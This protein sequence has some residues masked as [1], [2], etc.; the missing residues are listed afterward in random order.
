MLK[1][2]WNSRSGLQGSQNKIDIVS[3]NI[4]NVETTGYKKLDVTFQNA[5]YESMNGKGTPIT[6]EEPQRLQQGSGSIAESIVRNYKE[7]AIIATSSLSDMAIN[8]DGF[9]ELEDNEGSSFYTRDGAF[10]IDSQGNFVHST[11]LL[12][13]ID[14]YEKDKLKS[15]FSISPIGEIISN[16]EIIGK[17]RTCNFINKDGMIATGNGALKSIEEPKEFYGT[18]IQSHLEKSN[19]DIVKELTDMIIA[20]RSF[21]MG[22]RAT[23]TSDELWQLTNN[24]RNK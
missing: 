19:V 14:G 10:K 3:N 9:F 22:A 17:I 11:G 12:L 2:L 5:V 21:S 8:G 13:K 7:G 6:A 1:A 16:N 20:Q 4:A 24:L 23:Q 15:D 18:I